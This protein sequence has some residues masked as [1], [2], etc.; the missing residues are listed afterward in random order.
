MLLCLL[1]GGL[2]V[3]IT[4]IACVIYIFK[5]LDEI[6]RRKKLLNATDELLQTV[7]KR[8]KFDNRVIRSLQS[9]RIKNRF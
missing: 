1:L 4:S 9:Y 5:E 6:D 2:I 3:I 8:T 7:S